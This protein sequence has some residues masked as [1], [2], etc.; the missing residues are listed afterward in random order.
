MLLCF[1]KS[2]C[3]RFINPA[4]LY[5]YYTH[6]PHLHTHLH[7]NSFTTTLH[8]RPTTQEITLTLH[9]HS[10][11]QYSGESVVTVLKESD[12]ECKSPT[13]EGERPGEW[14]NIRHLTTCNNSYTFTLHPILLLP[15]HLYLPLLKWSRRPVHSL[16]RLGHQNLDG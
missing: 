13:S 3:M 11:V 1:C 8:C 5:Q 12:F 4:Y 7:H 14:S 2:V 15:L 6:H 9:H 10:T 16:Y